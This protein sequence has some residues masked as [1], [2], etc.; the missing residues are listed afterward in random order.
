MSFYRGR[1]DSDSS[2]HGSPFFAPFGIYRD[3]AFNPLEYSATH[4][5]AP[6]PSIFPDFHDI[7]RYSDDDRTPVSH[8]SPGLRKS[9]PTSELT[10][11]SMEGDDAFIDQIGDSVASGD[12]FSSEA[13]YRRL[14]ADRPWQRIPMDEVNSVPPQ[15]AHLL[16]SLKGENLRFGLLR[17]LL[18]FY[19]VE[20][21]QNLNLAH[22]Q[23]LDITKGINDKLTNMELIQYAETLGLFPLAVRLHLEFSGFIELPV[24]R[25][26]YISYKRERGRRRDL[27]SRL[28]S[29]AVAN[30]TSVS[31]EGTETIEYYPGIELKLG[32]ERDTVIRPMVTAVFRSNRD[33]FKEALLDAGLKYGE[34][35]MWKDAQLCTAL[36]IA[37]QFRPGI[38]DRAAELHMKKSVRTRGGDRRSIPKRRDREVH[39]EPY[40][41][42]HRMSLRNNRSP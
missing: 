38:W 12:Q 14:S 1:S 2:P 4:T 20:A 21:I 9:E 8:S 34:L 5:S 27:I 18:R 11:S 19:I 30:S 40:S 7:N 37:D 36:H 35:R 26:E 42:N 15:F 33:A 41:R 25:R 24:E 29:Q 22:R 10:E 13:D 17:C 6:I 3:D 16:T 32:K 31:A 39:D 28:R 23:E